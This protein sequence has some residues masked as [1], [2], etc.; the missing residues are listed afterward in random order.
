MHQQRARQDFDLRPVHGDD[1]P[2][3]VD[4]KALAGDHEPAGAQE[5]AFPEGTTMEVTPVEDEQVLGSISD[6]LDNK[7]ASLKAID[8]SFYDA[9]GTLIEP[10]TAISVKMTSKTLSEYEEPSIVHV[11]VDEDGGK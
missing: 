2:V 5:G 6:A 7:A 11:E 3:R 9:E 10:K 1:L 8:I 4:A